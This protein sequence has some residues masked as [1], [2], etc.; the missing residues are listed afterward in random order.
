MERNTTWST[1]GLCTGSDAD[2]YKPVS[3]A[4]NTNVLILYKDPVNFKIKTDKLLEVISKW[5]EKILVVIN[6]GKNCFSFAV[7]NQK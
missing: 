3:F 6:Y 2:L 5:F 1:P 4:G 7:S